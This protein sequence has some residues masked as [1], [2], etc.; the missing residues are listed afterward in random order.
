MNQRRSAL[1]AVYRTLTRG[2]SVV[3][4]A[5]GVLVAVALA[6]SPAVAQT[7]GTAP[8]F[9]SGAVT[10]VHGDAVQVTNQ[11]Q[12]SESTVVLSPTTQVTKRVTAST[13]AIT[14]G[15]CVRVTGTGSATKGI[16]ARS[17]ALSAATSSGCNAAPG[18]AA[19]GGSGGGGF[20]FGNGQRPR[21]FGNGNGNGFGNR[22]GARTAN[23]ALASG[24]VVS[25]KGDKIVVKSTTFQRPSTTS[26][27]SGKKKSTS[28]GTRTATPTMKTSNVTVTLPSAV[29]ISETVAGTTADVAVGSCV[30]A[31]G[32]NSAGSVTANRVVVSQPVSGSCTAGFGFGGGPRPGA[33]G[34]NG[35]NGSV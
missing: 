18:G 7:A 23:F 1:M 10:S 34:G 6:A 27:T 30:T 29:A 20:R 32:T 4:A 13:S 26:T 11:T 12:N 9:A 19:A 35:T 21:N 25:V 17:V 16:T 33:G 31:T 3:A 22:G 14:V 24:P 2:R 28:K 15:A 8:Q 5:A